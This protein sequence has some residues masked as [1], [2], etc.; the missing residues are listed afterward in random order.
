MTGMRMVSGHQEASSLQESRVPAERL[1]LSWLT[2]GSCARRPAAWEEVTLAEEKEE[3]FN[4]AD[5]RVAAVTLCFDKDTMSGRC[6][7]GLCLRQYSS[8]RGQEDIL[9]KW[10]RV[11]RDGGG[12]AMLPGPV[13]RRQAS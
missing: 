10:S 4:M 6:H 1:Y 9:G 11:R 8:H 7:P 2:D 13:E 12:R 5:F 3:P